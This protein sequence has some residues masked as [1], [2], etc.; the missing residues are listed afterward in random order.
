VTQESTTTVKNRVPLYQH[1]VD[2]AAG[3]GELCG[4]KIKDSR[5]GERMKRA[6]VNVKKASETTEWGLTFRGWAR[7]EGVDT[8]GLHSKGSDVESAM[9][10]RKP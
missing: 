10:G 6:L 4:K 5:G 3:V 8:E 7:K 9:G 2:S 1:K